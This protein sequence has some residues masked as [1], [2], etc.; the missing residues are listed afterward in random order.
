M[1]LQAK[2]LIVHCLLLALA[3]SAGPAAA[4]GIVVT[5]DTATVRQ[6]ESFVLSFE[7]DDVDGEPE[8][9]P[10]SQDFEILGKSQRTNIGIANGRMQ[11]ST[12]WQ[13]K[14]LP[15]R[16]G[17]VPIPSIAF[18]SDH[19]EAL[20]LTIA[21]P[22]GSDPS[23]IDT[24][25]M[26]IE[27]RA[28]PEA[29]Y[30]QAQVLLTV[31]LT[32]PEDVDLV[33]SSI[34]DPHLSG[35]D[36]L[37][38]LLGKPRER[39]AMEGGVRVRVLE[40]S[41]A[42]FPQAH[43]RLTIDPIDFE[44]QVFEG[45]ASVDDPFSQSIKT[46]KLRSKPIAIEVKPI[47]TA[48][49]GKHWLPATSVELVENW[50]DDTKALKAGEPI[51]RSVSLL[52]RGVT[53]GQLPELEI[54][55]D[56]N[57]RSYP[58]QPTLD[59]QGRSDGVIGLRMEKHALIAQANGTVTLPEIRIPW[60]NTRTDKL[61]EAI[62]PARTLKVEGGPVP[63]A[64]AEGVTSTSTPVA[65]ATGTSS[66]PSTAPAP[67][68]WSIVAAMLALG[69]AATAAAWWYR[70][71]RP[72]A[73]V[74]TVTGD[75][76]SESKNRLQVARQRVLNAAR[77]NDAAATRHALAQWA[78]AIGVQPPS[79]ESIARRFPD[80]AADLA[81]LDRHLY[82]GGEAWRGEA[83]RGRIE[84]MIVDLPD[85]P[86]PEGIGNDLPPLHPGTAS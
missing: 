50:S 72:A 42:V 1:I 82:A 55:T 4:A 57:L 27:V 53:A 49:T 68:R 5:V 23:D 38:T 52:A 2:R 16:A 78:G 21:A 83:L 85:K 81:T 79:I 11:K 48:F 56:K 10:L 60:W 25:A 28:T 29:P 71:R 46:V 9:G 66:A 69:W 64:P 13:L 14:L 75:A 24:H 63:A 62:I 7:A 8:F 19:S 6:G 74:T 67:T 30:V 18:G 41:F 86:T 80:L 31:R 37:I 44:G 17:E 84:K 36:A 33:D 77:Q 40:R 32:I 20:T 59:D 70:S 35:G 76:R 61:Q 3:A 39:L 58:E 51:T 54:I 73:V 26:R 12:V 22:A 34:G 45:S 47:P 15:K 65:K 43:G